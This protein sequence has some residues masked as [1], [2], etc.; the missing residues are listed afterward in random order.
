MKN[1]T[2]YC[3]IVLFKNISSGADRKLLKVFY[4]IC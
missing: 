4:L 3:Y 1:H 2:K